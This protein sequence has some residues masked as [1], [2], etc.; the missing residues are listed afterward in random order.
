MKKDL[1]RTNVTDWPKTNGIFLFHSLFPSNLE[2]LQPT[3]TFFL[4]YEWLPFKQYYL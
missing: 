3:E 4:H 1:V 2:Q